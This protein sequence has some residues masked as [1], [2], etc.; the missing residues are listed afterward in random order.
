MN[1][2]LALAAV[3]IG[4]PLILFV[5]CAAAALWAEVMLWLMQR[6]GLNV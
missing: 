3:F 6:G 5:F 2:V 4:L 1:S